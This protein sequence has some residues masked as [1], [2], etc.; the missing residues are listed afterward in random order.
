MRG[1]GAAF[2]RYLTHPLVRENM[3]ERRVYQERI[4]ESALEGNTLVVAP[5]ALGK[6]V[7]AVLLAA[8]FLHRFSEGKVAVLAPTRPLCAQHA[9]SFTRFLKLTA[10]DVALLTGHA[11]PE[12]RA[13]MWRRARVVCA[14]PHVVLND[15]EA[16][17]YTTAELSLAVFDEAHRAVGDYP[18]PAIASQLD[19]RILALTASP[20]GSIETIR[21]V[22]RNLRIENVEV[23]DETDPDVAPYVKP[24]QVEWRKVRLPEPYLVIKNLLTALLKERL[25]LLKSQGLLKSAG[26]EVSKKDL[27]SLLSQLQDAVGEGRRDLYHALSAASAALTLAHAL[28]LLETQGMDTLAKYLRRTVEKGGRRDASRAL[29][30]LARDHRFRRVLSMAEL[31]SERYRDPKLEAL[32]EV[33]RS[34]RRGM[35]IIVFTQYRDTA[36]AIVR[37]LNDMEGVRAV[38]FVGQASREEDAGLSQREQLEIIR[39]FREGAYNILVATSVAEEGLDIPAVDL[40]VFYEPVP[41]EIRAIQRRGRTGRSRAGRVLVLMAERTR[42]EG[43]YWSS[44]ARERQMKKSIRRL[45]QAFSK[46][47]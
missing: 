12:K 4:V 18:Y 41:S 8:D 35:K 13:E 15:L 32:M 42:D 17:R 21:E 5:T 26:A 22:C 38:R 39:G 11:K 20:G 24:V 9:A 44:V 36:A 16:G 30:S 23:R 2:S 6:T 7:I 37:A 40:V 25:T 46:S 14:T 31:V 45:K 1:S 29:K 10:E 19:C 33:I 28:E 47:F 34:V 3:L 43:F 27:L